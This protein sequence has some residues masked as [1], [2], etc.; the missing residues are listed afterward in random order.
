M[1]IQ[2]ANRIERLPPY[3]LG[4]L[5]QLIYERRRAGADVIDM[6]MGNPTDPPPGRVETELRHVVDERRRLPSPASVA[7]HPEGFGER[8]SHGSAACRM[9]RAL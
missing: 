7:S 1:K 6:N 4:K 8:A 9:R 5:K 2:V 3:M